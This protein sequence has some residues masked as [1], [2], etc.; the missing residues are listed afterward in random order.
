VA[1]ENDYNALVYYLNEL[2]EQLVEVADEVERGL[3]DE[4]R[5]ELQ[6]NATKWVNLI[7]EQA[8]RLSGPIESVG[9]MAEMVLRS[10]PGDAVF[11]D[12]RPPRSGR[13]AA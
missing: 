10:Q 12:Q 5:N 9:R 11:K 13:A 8:L 7:A 2:T 6:P 1:V 4:K 3:L